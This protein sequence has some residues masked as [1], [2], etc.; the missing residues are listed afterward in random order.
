MDSSRVP[1]DSLYS[2]LARLVD[3]V[4]TLPSEEPNG[5]NHVV[6]GTSRLAGFSAERVEYCGVDVAELIERFSFE[7]VVWLLLTG[8]CPDEEELADASAI[9]G[10]SVI[11]QSVVDVISALPLRTRPIELL[12]LGISLLSQFEP[13][14]G[15]RSFVAARSRVW[16]LLGQ[17]P[18]LLTFGLSDHWRFCATDSADASPSVYGS[19]AASFLH[20]LRCSEMSFAAPV[21]PVEEEAMNS[22]LICHCLTPLRP[23]CFAA[24]FFGST[25]DDIEPSLRAAA[26][27]YVAQTRND[28]WQWAAEHLRSFSTPDAAE[29]W[30]RQRGDQFM[31]FGFDES[32]EDPRGTLLARVSRTL[33][34]SEDHIRVTA[35]AARIQNVME[36][37][38][39]YPTMDWHTAVILTLLDIPPDRMSL[40]VAISRLAG[41]AAQALD[42]Q[43]SGVSLMPQLQY[44]L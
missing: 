12:P 31:P 4:S 35:S 27:L 36:K 24:R 30:L 33:L 38:K 16:R 2:G 34:G 43:A 14:R 5:L 17:L 44:A 20:Q 3:A 41:W 39:Q 13:T 7:G 40:V 8:E 28:P 19:F 32:I 29:A 11:E 25:V 22:V 15:D 6:C 9:L 1:A 37:H 10:E 23:A 26:S 42:Q 18:Q 21:S